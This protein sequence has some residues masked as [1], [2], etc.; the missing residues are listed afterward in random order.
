MTHGKAPAIL[1]ESTGAQYLR[2]RC[3]NLTIS[4]LATAAIA[5]NLIALEAQ[6]RAALQPSP[7]ADLIAQARAALAVEATP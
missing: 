6:L 2:R 4:P 5:S 1:A 3:P 7:A